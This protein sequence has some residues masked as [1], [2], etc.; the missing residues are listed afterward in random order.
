MSE[1]EQ[2]MSKLL[3]DIADDHPVLGE[4]RSQKEKAAHS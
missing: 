4:L 1:D 3:G 2:R